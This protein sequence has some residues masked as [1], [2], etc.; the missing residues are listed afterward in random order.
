M[1]SLRLRLL[2]QLRLHRAQLTGRPRH[3]FRL[4]DQADQV[5]DNSCTTTSEICTVATQFDLFPVQ[6][7]RPYHTVRQSLE[8]W[9]E[10]QMKKRTRED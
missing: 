2:R 3:P 7:S 4:T 5:P 10:V 1:G 9:E 8:V 6:P